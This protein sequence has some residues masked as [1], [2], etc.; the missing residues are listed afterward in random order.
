[1]KTFLRLGQ[2]L[3]GG[4]LGAAT[5]FALTTLSFVGLALLD[6]AGMARFLTRLDAICVR[7]FHYPAPTVACVNGHAIAGG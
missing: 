5:G 6:G 3:L 7:L 1:M 2:G 4:L